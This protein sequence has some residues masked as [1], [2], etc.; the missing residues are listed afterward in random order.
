[1]SDDFEIENG[2]NEEKITC[3]VCTTEFSQGRTC[4]NCGAECPIEEADILDSGEPTDPGIFP[5]GTP[6]APIEVERDAREM[7]VDGIDIRRDP[8][9][10]TQEELTITVNQ[11]RKMVL[12][13]AGIADATIA[14]GIKCIAIM[15]QA[16]PAKA[17]TA[18]EK[19][20]VKTMSL[21]DF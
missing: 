6:A 9:T 1:M 5:E 7:L 11:I 13:H 8:T 18:R 19:V 12:D 15:R 10:L 17:G 14:Y 4:P 2:D 21:D 3:P 20:M 16:R